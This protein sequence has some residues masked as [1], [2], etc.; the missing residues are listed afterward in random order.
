[1]HGPSRCGTAP[2]I[3]N[4]SWKNTVPACTD[5]HRYSEVLLTELGTKREREHMLRACLACSEYLDCV[6][7]VIATG[8]AWEFHQIQVA[9]TKNSP[10]T[11]P[12]P[13]NG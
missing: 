7:D 6:E 9:T 3:V 1:M 4:E 8:K 10:P 13:R 11:D 12:L 5:D 2:M